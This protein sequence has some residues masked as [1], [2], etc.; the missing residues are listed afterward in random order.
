[1]IDPEGAGSP[2]EASTGS[3]RAGAVV[4]LV[5]IAAIVSGAVSAGVTL[6]I[7]HA[8]SRTNPQTV[9]LG[10]N[11]TITEDSAIIQV[12]D[13]AA[14]AVATID[15]GGAGDS[16]LGS[17]FVTTSDGYIVT[18]AHVIANATALTVLFAGDATRHDARLVDSD[19]QTDVAV[20]KVD[21]VSNLPT[22]PFGDTSTLRVGQPVVV[23]G[24]P[25][26][27][28]V[29]ESGIIA[30]LHRAITVAGP[31]T[32]TAP[33]TLS[34]TFQTDAVSDPADSGAPVLNVAGQ[35]VGV[36]VDTVSGGSQTGFALSAQ[37]VQTEVEQIV[38]DGR[39]VVPTLGATTAQVTAADAAF[40]GSS[41]G[42]QVVT[43][44]AGGPAAAAG[45]QPDDVITA[46]DEVKLDDAHPLQQ[47][48]I[49]QFRQ[50]QKVTITLQRGGSTTQVQATLG[51]GHPVCG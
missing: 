33:Q 47:V 26:G 43:V 7:L 24:T 17:G 28:R 12:A 34:D 6:A 32:P 11:V 50:G 3:R 37:D 27:G 4:A 16:G 2:P 5:V 25:L 21:G 10:S 49:E 35:V 36:A 30:A 19:C 44:A 8:Q 22:L 48:L 51:G 42:A 46:V 15:T 23:V 40:H 31:V 38:R 14:P 1:M 39:L 45:I 18:N 13:K 29:V 41:P 20:L 9:D